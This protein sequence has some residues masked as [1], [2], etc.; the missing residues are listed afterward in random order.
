MKI[1]EKVEWGIAWSV[2]A[3]VCVVGLFNLYYVLRHR[4][5]DVFSGTIFVIFIT[6]VVLIVLVLIY[7]ISQKFFPKYRFTKCIEKAIE[8]F[9]DFLRNINW[10]ALP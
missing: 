10:F 3:S 8:K 2:L 7:D 1:K 6:F 4:A 9:F 5:L